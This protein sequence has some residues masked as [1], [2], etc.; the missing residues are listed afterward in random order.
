MLTED[1]TIY[2]ADFGTTATLSSGA[3]V[4]GIF[5]AAA[6]DVLTAAS[7]GPSFTAATANLSGL[8]YGATLTIASVG[9]TVRQND[10]DGTG[11]ST[12]TLER[13]T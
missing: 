4:T 10:P 2:F 6:M 11:V 13:T 7:I 12:L 9:Y 3:S 8:A 1:L 5:D